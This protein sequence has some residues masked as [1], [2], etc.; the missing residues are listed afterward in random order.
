[1]DDLKIISNFMRYMFNQWNEYEAEQVF[2][3][4]PGEHIYSKYLEYNRNVPWL[5]LNIDNDCK[6]KLIERANHFYNK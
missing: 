4:L 5:F 3:E 1:M 2:G 6:R